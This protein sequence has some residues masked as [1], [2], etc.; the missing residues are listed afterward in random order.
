M[1]SSQ[2]SKPHAPYGRPRDYLNNQFV[3]LRISAR[4]GGLTVGAN[5]NPDKN[6]NFDCVYCEVDRV[7]VPTA[8]QLDVEVMAAELNQTLA[9]VRAGKLREMPGYHSLPDQLLQ[10]RHV[11]LSGDGE[12]TLSPCF[13]EAIQ[14]VTH[15][16]AL[17]GFAFFKLVLMTNGAGL[18]LPLVQQSLARFTRTDRV[19]IKLDGGTEAYLNRINGTHVPLDRILANIIAFGRQRPVVI[20]SLFPSYRGE[21]PPLEEIEQY[22]LRLRELKDAGAQISLVQIYSALRPTRS[23][24]YAHLPL[25]ELSRIAQ[26]VRQVADLKAE[27]F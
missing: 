19:W 1:I 14:A 5:L 3:Y 21:P 2:S 27:V 7:T 11:S 22:A 17:G 24:E 20:Q 10:L 15:V 16:R 12:P 8:P 25:K 18:A 9:L 23:P 13:A 4:A 26:R 6:C